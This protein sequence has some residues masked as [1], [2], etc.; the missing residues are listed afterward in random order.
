MIKVRLG[1]P[2][3]RPARH[4]PAARRRILGEIEEYFA[5]TLTPGD[6]FLFAGEVL[7]FEGIL[8]DEVLA[9]RAKA[10]TDPKIPSYDGG[11]FPLSTFL[12]ARVRGDPRR[13]VRMGPPAA[14]DRPMAPAA[15]PPLHRARARATSSSRPSRAAAAIT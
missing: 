12:A 9:T 13:S 2:C 8:E 6:T 5:E 11:K 7:R 15:A 10:G 4:R 3:A 14:A 1:Q